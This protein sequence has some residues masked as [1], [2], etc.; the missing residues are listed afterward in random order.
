M[1]NM[2]SDILLAEI[3]DLLARLINSQSL[4]KGLLE[5]NEVLRK[6]IKMQA[7]DMVSLVQRVGYLESILGV[8]V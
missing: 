6:L 2:E 5:S 3:E 8:E 4:G 7:K 1:S